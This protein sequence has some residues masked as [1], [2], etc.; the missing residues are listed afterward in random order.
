MS[1]HRP[2]NLIVVL[3]L[4]T[5]IGCGGW[6]SPGSDPLAAILVERGP[7]GFRLD[8]QS[9]HPVNPTVDQLGVAYADDTERRRAREAQALL[10]ESGFDAGYRRWWTKPEPEGGRRTVV[11]AIVYRFGSEAAATGYLDTIARGLSRDPEIE[12]PG[13]SVARFEIDGVT[14]AVAQA[15]T[16]GDQ[17]TTNAY[18][19]R[20]KYWF[21]IGATT[22]ATLAGAVALTRSVAKS[23]FDLA[24]VNGRPSR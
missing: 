24:S 18:F 21:W 14:G 23:Q 10:R 22:P 8:P 19:V 16:S 9:S 2:A 6:T 12:R 5:A 13:R 17:T 20:D 15:V 4:A 7:D 3:V 1:V 11:F